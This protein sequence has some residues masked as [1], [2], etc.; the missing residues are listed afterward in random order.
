MTTTTATTIDAALLATLTQ[1]VDQALGAIATRHGL[2]LHQGPIRHNETLF[3]RQITFQVSGELKQATAAEEAS[4][5][6]MAHFYGLKRE[7][8]GQEFTHGKHRY[9]V[10]G[11]HLKAR[12]N[13]VL[14]VRLDNNRLYTMTAD[15]ARIAITKELYV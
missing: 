4:F 11:L 2:M 3:H 5:T 12:T 10:A 9:R 8:L 14:V 13:V 15:M 6:N 1:E 7:W